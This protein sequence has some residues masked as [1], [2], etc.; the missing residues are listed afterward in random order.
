MIGLIPEPVFM[1]VFAGAFIVSG[2]YLFCVF[3]LGEESAG[4]EAPWPRLGCA[5]HSFFGRWCFWGHPGRSPAIRPGRRRSGHALV[6][7]CSHPAVSVFPRV[8]SDLSPTFSC[9]S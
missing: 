2:V 6:K 5:R 1:A 4:S 3:K 8:P 7:L 9:T